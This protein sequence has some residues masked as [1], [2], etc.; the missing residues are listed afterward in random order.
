MDISPRHCGIVLGISNTL[1]TLPGIL[2]NVST[3]FMLEHGM[4]VD[5]DLAA[6]LAQT[7]AAA[8]R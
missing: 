2:C 3:G 1:A 8:P 7:R 6:A 5:R 4:G